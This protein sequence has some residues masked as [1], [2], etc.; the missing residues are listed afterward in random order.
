[1]LKHKETYT[2]VCDS[3][4]KE[5]EL[6]DT[7][8]LSRDLENQIMFTNEFAPRLADEKSLKYIAKKRKR[9]F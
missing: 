4:D 2:L 5:K 1:M 3:C 8:K 7:Q 6:K 9:N